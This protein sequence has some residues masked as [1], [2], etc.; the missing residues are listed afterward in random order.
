MTP[1]FCVYTPF[2]QFF[3]FPF[4][5]SQIVPKE[6]FV[7]NLLFILFLMLIIIVLL[8]VD[9]QGQANTYIFLRLFAQEKTES[10]TTW[11]V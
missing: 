8:V 5:K 7:R 4:L 3:P 9:G 1:K 2:T 11:L 6:E 10:T